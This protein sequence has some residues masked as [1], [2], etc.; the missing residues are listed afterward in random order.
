MSRAASWATALSGLALLLLLCVRVHAPAIEAE[1]AGQTR[2]AL[3]GE[4]VRDLAVG[5]DGRDVVLTGTVA[6]DAARARAARLAAS[7]R[8]V[9]AVD[10]RLGVVDTAR[11]GRLDLSSA[12]DSGLV[13]RGAVPTRAAREALGA[14]LRRA[15]PERAVTNKV[16]VDARAEAAW[17]PVALAA[18]SALSTLPDDIL[19]ARGLSVEPDVG[20]GEVVVRGTVPDADAR[21]QVE[22]AMQSVV[23]APWTLRSELSVDAPADRRGTWVA[24]AAPGAPDV[25]EAQAALREVFAAGAV[26]FEPGTPRLTAASCRLLER[27]AAVLRRAPGVTVE[28]QGHTDAEGSAASNLRLSEQRA[29]AVR[30]ALA[31][32]GVDR[33]RLTVRGFGETEPVAPNDTE[34]GRARNRRVA[35]LLGTDSLSP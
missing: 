11:L 30:H 26:E 10:N 3:S 18:I 6:S 1:L 12:P 35:L 4:A 32:G 27:A 14:R 34:A 23:E 9:R 19:A 21:V 31:D 28:I 16:A 29:A 8:G 25:A 22:A 33:A 7:V 24:S 15:F 2:A 17:Q 5:L 13:A 20:G